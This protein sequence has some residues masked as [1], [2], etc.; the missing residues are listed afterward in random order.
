[1]PPPIVLGMAACSIQSINSITLMLKTWGHMEDSKS[2]V[3]V[4]KDFTFH[5]GRETN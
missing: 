3:P 2:K 1:M 4:L 5:W